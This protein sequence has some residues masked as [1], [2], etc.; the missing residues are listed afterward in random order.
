MATNLTACSQFTNNFI[1]EFVANIFFV[2][3]FLECQNR[4]RIMSPLRK[5]P[6]APKGELVEYQ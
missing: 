5:L 4:I 2:L 6:L 1:R 3:N